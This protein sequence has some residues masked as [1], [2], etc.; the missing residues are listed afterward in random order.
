MLEQTLRITQTTEACELPASTWPV[1]TY[2]IE[3]HPDI[4]GSDDHD[5]PEIPCRRQKRNPVDVLL[6]PVSPWALARA[7]YPV[8][9]RH[10]AADI[11][12]HSF[13][14]HWSVMGR[15]HWSL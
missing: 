5:G 7:C 10:A 15:G 14:Y 9:S 1:G 2:R 6:S 12:N 3:L 8:W 13:L 11:D 4:T